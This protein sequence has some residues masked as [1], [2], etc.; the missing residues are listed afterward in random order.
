MFLTSEV[1][2][3]PTTWCGTGVYV[4]YLGRAGSATRQRTRAWWFS[5]TAS[6]LLSL[7]HLQGNLA[8]KK[9]PPPRTLQHDYAWVIWWFYGGAV[10]YE[11]GT[12]Q[13]QGH[14]GERGHG[15]PPRQLPSCAD[16]MR[17]IQDSQDQ[18]PALT[19]LYDCLTDPK[20][21]LITPNSN[22]AGSGTR[23]RMRAWLSCSIASR[24]LRLSTS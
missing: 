20:H 9:H 24:P 6:P 10:S 12:P 13:V 16:R 11:R 21:S 18:I 5:S 15:G 2:L 1:P 8:H 4:P 19:V 23:R 14:G 22:P 7:L 17:H 3:Y